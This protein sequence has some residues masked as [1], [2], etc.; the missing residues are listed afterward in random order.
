MPPKR[1][2]NRRRPTVATSTKMVD[3]VSRYLTSNRNVSRVSMPLRSLTYT[4]M[5]SAN[6]IYS[7]SS[8]GSG[9]GGYVFP[10]HPGR[11][12]LTFNAMGGA[13][14]L[15]NTEWSHYA[16][17]YDE[18]RVVAIIIEFV[19]SSQTFSTQNEMYTLVDY[20]NELGAGALTASNLAARYQTAKL[21]SPTQE[22]Q[23]VANFPLSGRAFP[24]WQST[25]STT[26]RG[27]VYTFLSAGAN[28]TVLGPFVAKWIVQFR[29]LNG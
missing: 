23:F 27:S 4:H 6:G 19:P 25:A 10:E 2:N 29:A 12:L 15:Q 8:T 9:P 26:A 24:Q 14:V 3:T 7:F 28:S 5:L 17:L 18:F 22:S 1:K 11:N 21:L 16:A 20:D 13:G